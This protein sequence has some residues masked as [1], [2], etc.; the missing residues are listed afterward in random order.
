[1]VQKQQFIYVIR[2]IRPGFKEGF[3]K[4]EEE[5]MGRHLNYLKDL[6]EKK[7]AILV[8]PCLD[9]AFGICIFEAES[10]EAARKIT[11]NDPAIKEKVMTAEL[12]AFKVSLMRKND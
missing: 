12:H 7:A 3:T 11:E 2:P 8:G 9:A 10:E 6:I 4:E 5:I 1:M